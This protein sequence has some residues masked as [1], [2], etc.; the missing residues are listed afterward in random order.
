MYPLRSL[1]LAAAG[2]DALRRALVRAPGSKGIVER[3]VAGET[4]ADAVTAAGRLIDDGLYVTLDY[5]GENT[6]E[7]GQAEQ[8]A[9]TYVELL[10]RLHTEG[11]AHRAEVS[12]KLSAIG[13]LLD[14]KLAL[15]NAHL[16]R[17]FLKMLKSR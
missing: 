14:E 15:D 11:L 7:T 9:R 3:F 1:I 17:E 8:T 16:M 4:V 2:S 6:G 13:L 5:L 10:A 12:V